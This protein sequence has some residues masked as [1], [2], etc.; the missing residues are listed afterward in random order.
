MPLPLEARAHWLTI[1][2][3]VD[4]HN[5][6]FYDISWESPSVF[7]GLIRGKTHIVKGISIHSN[8]PKLVDQHNIA[9]KCLQATPKDDPLYTYALSQIDHTNQILPIEH[10]TVHKPPKTG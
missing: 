5:R 9:E 6:A 1:T 10:R 4:D 8:I 3:K 2:P 7:F